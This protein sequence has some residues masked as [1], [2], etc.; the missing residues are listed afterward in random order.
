MIP[1]MFGHAKS[2][3]VVTEI[4]KSSEK[5]AIPLKLM[6]SLGMD[7]PNWTAKLLLKSVEVSIKCQECKI[8]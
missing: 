2:P 8:H 5:L 4:L 3:D 6:L 7:G 1:I